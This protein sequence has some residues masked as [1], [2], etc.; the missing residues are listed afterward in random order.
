M[1]GEDINPQFCVPLHRSIVLDIPGANCR[2]PPSI[3][4]MKLDSVRGSAE[5]EFL[6]MPV[7]VGERVQNAGDDRLSAIPHSPIHVPF[8]MRF[9][10]RSTRAR[11]N[12]PMHTLRRKSLTKSCS[13]A[14]QHGDSNATS[15]PQQ[16]PDTQ[17]HSS[18]A[19]LHA[20][21]QWR[22]C[23]CTMHGRITAQTAQALAATR[24]WTNLASVP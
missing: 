22:L 10:G 8:A 21:D 6:G 15:P 16:S 1:L 19:S 3:T 17:C 18:D 2:I 4:H 23:H 12:A 14:E 9:V 13:C 7:R 20:N 24:S 5:K 11:S